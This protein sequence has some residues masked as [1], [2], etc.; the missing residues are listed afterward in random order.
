[1]QQTPFIIKGKFQEDSAMIGQPIHY[2]LYVKH[3][4][5]QEVFFPKANQS[6]G[7]F[8]TVK[9]EFF[10]TKTTASG[11]LDSAVYT[12]RLFNLAPVQK[13]QIPIYIQQEPDCTL[14]YPVVDS[15]YLKR[16]LPH[17]EQIDLDSL[18]QSIPIQPVSPKT[19]LKNVVAAGISLL[20]LAGL[21][22]WIF[23]KAITK[24][25]KR[26]LLWRRHREFRRTFQR[27]ARQVA[28]T[29]VGLSNL[30]KAFSTW[31]KYVEALTQL[32]F[33][34]FTSKEMLDN[35]ADETMEKVLNEM[36][37]AIYGGNFSTNTVE[38]VQYLDALAGN[39][40]A[41]EQEKIQNNE[42]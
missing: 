30:E 42:V 15:I 27:Y 16:L 36:D 2:S 32:P 41:L 11:S 14:I 20:I 22:Y 9:R 24:L 8:E 6:F 5:D 28:G 19:D 3:P 13:L 34:T 18:Y 1:M 33:T 25:F 23:G 7:S 29:P 10:A 37:S 38:S 17:P 40:Y 4:K 12:L 31:K 26:Y 39:L 35:L 21:I